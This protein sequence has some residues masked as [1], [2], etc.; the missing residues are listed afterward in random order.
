MDETVVFT[1]YNKVHSMNK[2]ISLFDI[3]GIFKSEISFLVNGV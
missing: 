3:F 1:P 2:K